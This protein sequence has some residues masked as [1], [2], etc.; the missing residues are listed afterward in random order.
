M[1]KISI[2]P[3]QVSLPSSEKHQHFRLIDEFV[4]RYKIQMQIQTNVLSDRRAQELKH[5]YHFEP[6]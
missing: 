1:E 6:P 2:N 5:H 3:L 4:A